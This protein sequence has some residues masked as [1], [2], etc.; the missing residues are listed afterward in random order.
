MC[1]NFTGAH[2]NYLLTA[3]EGHIFQS[4]AFPIFDWSHL[5]GS[6]VFLP[7]LVPDFPVNLPAP[8]YFLSPSTLCW[9]HQFRAFW[10]PCLLLLSLDSTGIC[11]I[12]GHA[13]HKGNRFQISSSSSCHCS[14]DFLMFQMSPWNRGQRWGC[15][16]SACLWVLLIVDCVVKWDEQVFKGRKV[17]KI[18]L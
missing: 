10:M 14:W 1:Q 9:A 18:C 13:R 5:L 11:G 12:F 15:A 7:L 6:S 3:Q 4:L 8:Q 16:R 2:T 17:G